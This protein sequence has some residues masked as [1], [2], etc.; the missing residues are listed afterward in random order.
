MVLRQ[1]LAAMAR[2][3]AL[4][5]I[6]TSFSAS[7]KVEGETSGPTA[8]PV[9]NAGGAPGGRS[10]GCCAKL[11]Y[12]VAAANKPRDVW[13]RNCLRYFAMNPPTGIVAG[14][15]DLGRK[16]ALTTES[17]RHGENL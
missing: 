15:C 6:C 14:G 11:R 10:V 16:G 5:S 9:P 4:N 1:L 7:A 2:S 13:V 3:L 12:A 17:Q 8:G